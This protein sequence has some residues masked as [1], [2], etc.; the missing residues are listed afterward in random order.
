MKYIIETYSNGIV[1]I[2][3]QI[4]GRK[5]KWNLRFYVRNS[6]KAYTKEVL[7]IRF[8]YAVV[9]ESLIQLSLALACANVQNVQSILKSRKD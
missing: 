9:R 2:A 1:L 6:A 7:S 4:K 3:K 8:P 5:S